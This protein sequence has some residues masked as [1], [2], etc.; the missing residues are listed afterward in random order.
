M[1]KLHFYS[2]ALSL[3]EFFLIGMEANGAETFV[4][5]TDASKLIGRCSNKKNCCKVG[6]VDHC[7]LSST[8]WRDGS[9][10]SML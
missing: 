10:W 3:I 9:V 4:G 5:L 1:L 6:K 7:V 8:S 2:V